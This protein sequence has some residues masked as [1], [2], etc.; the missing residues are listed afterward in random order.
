MSAEAPK[1]VPPSS[2]NWPPAALTAADASNIRSLTES[3]EATGSLDPITLQI[4]M[5]V[6]LYQGDVAACRHLWRRVAD[7]EQTLRQP[8]APWWKVG[9]AMLTHNAAALWQALQELPVAAAAASEA[10]ASIPV[11]QYAQD[12][13]QAY[14]LRILKPY[15]TNTTTTRQQQGMTTAMRPPSFLVLL[16][17]FSSMQELEMFGQTNLDAFGNVTTRTG[18]TNLAMPQQAALLAFLEAQLAL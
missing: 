16:L 14:R 15:V 7:Q 12:I 8:L 10:S 9:A 17:G 4:Q 2:T 3:L 1:A 18:A 11:A 6:L 5:A 13:A